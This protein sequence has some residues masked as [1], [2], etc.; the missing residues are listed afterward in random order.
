MR[1]RAFRERSRFSGIMTAVAAT[2]SDET[3]RDIA[4]YYERL[5]ARAAGTPVDVSDTRAAIAARG[6]PDRDVPA[7][8]EC[9]G[10][11]AQPKNPAYPKLAGQPA[12]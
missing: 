1:T 8:A 6:I 5:P 11:S 2:L 3:M 12:R 9:H 10:P 7:C 4:A